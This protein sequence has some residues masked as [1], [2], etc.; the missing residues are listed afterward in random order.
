MF[1]EGDKMK[2]VSLKP[3]PFNIEVLGFTGINDPEF[4]TEFIDKYVD[5]E[6]AF[7]SVL[8]NKLTGVYNDLGWGDQFPVLNAKINKFFKFM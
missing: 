1:V 2:Y 3:N 5:R 8:L 6:D 4:I 7:N